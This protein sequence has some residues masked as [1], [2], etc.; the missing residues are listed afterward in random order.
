MN[1]LR[2]LR[3]GLREAIGS[4]GLVIVPVVAIS[5]VF[6]VLLL[7]GSF[8]MLLVYDDV[9]PSRSVPSLVSL[10]VLVM[11]AYGFQAVLDVIR[12]RIMVHVGSRFLAATSARVLNVVATHEL[13]RGP[14]PNGTQIVRD[15][16]TVRGF[17][18][19]A[20]PL[21][22]VDLPW[23]PVYLLI[24]SVFHWSLGLLALA[25][26]AVL[27]GL[28]IASNQ[29]TGPLALDTMKAGARRM[30]L[31][32]AT[33]RNAETLRALGMGP[34]RMAQWQDAEAE[35]LQANDRFSA[36]SST[37]SGAT[38]AFRM[39]LQSATLALGAYLVIRGSATGG[40]IIASSILSS[41]ALAPVEQV[42]AHW[43][44]AVSCAQAMSRMHDLMAAAPA[45]PEPLGLELPRAMLSVR[46]LACAPPGSKR[47]TL[48][49]VSFEL[50]AG[51]A[52]AV[53]G[54]SGSGKTTLARALCGVWPVA[55]GAVRLD[56]ATLDQWPVTQLA[57]FMGYVPQKIELFEGT[58]AQN[59]ARFRPDADRDKILAAA[60]AADCHD[61]IVRLDGGYDGVI[62]AGGGGL[63]AGQQ[64]RIALARAL[65]GDP[66]LVVL[67]EP[68][69]NLD[70]EGEQALAHAIGQHRQR[71]GIAIVIAHRPA[72]VSQVSHLLVMNTGKVQSFET[73]Q[74]FEARLR[75][76]GGDA[77]RSDAARAE[78][79]V[80]G[81]AQKASEKDQASPS[82][83]RVSEELDL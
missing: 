37:L 5:G 81:A 49:D 60:R 47:L 68:N 19:G 2:C 7:S 77:S 10:L 11:V 41:R 36:R 30:G 73:R 27:V 13:R 17:L 31:A 57:Q 3:D 70:H 46:S 16:D 51:D 79:R 34:A 35:Y 18:S 45:E 71:G 54:R 55:R 53:V 9:L 39:F 50:K 56:G 61:L 8:F 21:A 76:S 33:L 15:A 75:Q 32:E 22:I 58:V 29:A 72:I 24:L 1:L 66:F 44:S 6:N 12:G 52:L 40:I 4:L 62:A 38:K 82:E 26:V 69:S 78:Q 23:V 63:S 20:G 64:Q 25:G 59:I 28:M 48:A 42:I 14:L 83:A 74:E 43:K 67:D 65:Y 80:N